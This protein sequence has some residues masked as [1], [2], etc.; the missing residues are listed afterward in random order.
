[1]ALMTILPACAQ[2]LEL[3][4]F[5]LDPDTEGMTNIR[6]TPGGKVI[7]QLEPDY[8]SL[9][10]IVP[11]Q[12]NWWRIKG[13]VVQS[14]GE[15]IRI[16]AKEAWIHRSLLAV[17][18]D[19]EDG[20]VRKLYAE[21]RRDAKLVMVLHQIRAILRPL[22]LSADGKWVKVTYDPSEF[23]GRPCEKVTGWIEK[24]KVRDDAFEPGDGGPV[25][26]LHVSV[27]GKEEVIC[28][29]K[30]GAGAQTFML[31]KGKTYEFRVGNPKNGWWQLWDGYVDENDETKWVDDEAWMPA[32]AL[33][34]VVN[35]WTGAPT[36]PVYEKPDDKSRKLFDLKT[37][38]LV[39]PTEIAEW[40]WIK[41]YVDGHPEQTGWIA[42]S[43]LSGNLSD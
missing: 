8:Y 33:Y 26:T 9:T 25:P 17:A 27:P 40:S 36:V 34:N 38:T 20:Q 13:S 19:Y 14:D 37:G 10:A 5:I 24:S 41:V 43:K 28:R 35:D 29:E 23:E 15:E 21:P 22:A 16:P 30:P 6:A 32:S 1:M 4:C 12:G 2:S 18:A 42:W 31:E 3:N 11:Q 7:Y 39:H